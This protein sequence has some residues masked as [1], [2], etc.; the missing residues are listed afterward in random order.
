MASKGKRGADT[1]NRFT[2]KGTVTVEGLVEVSFPRSDVLHPAEPCAGGYSD[3]D[4]LVANQGWTG[5]V[6]FNFCLLLGAEY[7]RAQ[8]EPA[9]PLLKQKVAV[10]WG[11]TAACGRGSHPGPCDEIPPAL[12]PALK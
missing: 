12:T 5:D 8:R 1:H 3:I 11:K 10:P 4:W 7:R 9:T 6:L 2:E